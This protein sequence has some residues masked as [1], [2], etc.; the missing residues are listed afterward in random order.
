MVA[1]FQRAFNDF[2]YLLQKY[3]PGVLA[4]GVLPEPQHEGAA[5]T[6]HAP[7]ISSQNSNSLNIQ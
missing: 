2:V 4:D 1:N 6:A 3:V 7:F 5:Q